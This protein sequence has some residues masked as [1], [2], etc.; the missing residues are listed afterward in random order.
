MGVP[1]PAPVHAVPLR[2]APFVPRPHPGAEPDGHA[3]LTEPM[4]R[5]SPAVTATPVLAS[6]SGGKDSS[7]ALRAVLADPTRAISGLLT[8]VTAGYE[9]ISMHGVRAELLQ[10][11]A[12]ALG[13]PLTTARIPP[14]ASNEAYETAM[15][16]ALRPAR[17]AGITE[18]VFGDLF[19]TDVRAYRERLLAPM[20]MSGHYPLWG[21]PTGALATEFIADGFRAVLV[22][23]DPRQ[24]PADLCGREFDHALLADLPAHADPC[25]E[26][27]EFHTFVYDGP[28]FRAPVLWRRGAVVE[29]DGFWFCDLAA[30]GDAPEQRGA[31]GERSSFTARPSPPG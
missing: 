3:L 17:E 2:G 8:T 6:W 9:R 25:G 10:A 1:L 22:C 24:V 31:S 26:N 21:R 14:V 12:A 27:G 23:V 19:L 11:Q 5:S 15:R 29:R 13:L 16:A 4:T 28:I 7:L 30:A 20:G 18:V